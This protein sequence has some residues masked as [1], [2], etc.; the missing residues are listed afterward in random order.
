MTRCTKR[1]TT[2]IALLAGN[3][4]HLARAGTAWESRAAQIPSDFRASVIA[5]DGPLLPQGADDHIYRLC[6]AVF[7]RSPFHNRCKP[8]LSHWGFGLQ[9]RRASTEACAQFSQ[10][11]ASSLE[12]EQ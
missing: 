4:L 6:E 8:G 7:I 11:L 1:A 10:L 3:Q 9:L 5:I 2:A 12:K